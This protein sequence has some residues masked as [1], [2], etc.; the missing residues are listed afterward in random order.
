MTLFGHHC[1][2]EFKEISAFTAKKCCNETDNFPCKEGESVRKVPCCSFQ[3]ATASHDCHEIQNIH[4]SSQQ[5][6]MDAGISEFPFVSHFNEVEHRPCLEI[7]YG[8][9]E[10]DIDFQIVY[11][12]YRI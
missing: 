3:I 8:P 6:S 2:G 10:R 5:H 7:D 9:P 4:I 11:Q 1:R 12:V